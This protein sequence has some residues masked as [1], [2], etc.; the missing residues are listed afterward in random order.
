MEGSFKAYSQ[1]RKVRWT[2]EQIN[3]YVSEIKRFVDLARFTEAAMEQMVKLAFMACFP[4][5]ISV[6][7]QTQ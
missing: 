6:N 7:S 4:D 1:L 5:H 3:N 2:S